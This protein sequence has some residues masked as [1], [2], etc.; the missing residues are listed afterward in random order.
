MENGDPIN[1]KKKGGRVVVAT[2]HN[3]ESAKVYPEDCDNIYGIDHL[4]IGEAKHDLD[5]SKR[6][7]TRH[8]IGQMANK[9]NK[10]KSLTH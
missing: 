3:N 6:L 2:K 5:D 10:D 4:K 9:I 8:S 1:N 7:V